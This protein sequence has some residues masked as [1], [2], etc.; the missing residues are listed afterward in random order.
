LS[1][2]L[3]FSRFP[4]FLGLLLKKFALLIVALALVISACGGGD[5]E[6]AATVDG[7]DYTVGDV[8]DLVFDSGETVSKEQF[9]QFLGFLV[10]YDIV[11]NAAEE[12][13]GITFTED[14]I[15]EEA[16]EIYTENADEGTTYEEFL[17]A[18][19]VSEE[20]LR[21]VAHLQ[22]VEEG[23]RIEL[24]SELEAPAQEDIDAQRENAYDSLT[25]V[26]G[27]HIL[28][29][30]EAEAQE[31]LDRLED[32]EEFA[33]LATELSL[34][35]GSGEAGG[36]LG[37]ADPTGYVPE[38]AE[39]MLAAEIDVPTEPVE[40]EFGYHVI[41]VSERTFPEEADLPTDEEIIESLRVPAVNQALTD[42]IS[43]H[44]EAAEV[45]INEKFGT[46]QSSPAGVIPPVE[47]TTPTTSLDTGTTTTGEPTEE[48]TTTTGE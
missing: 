14:E 46:W 23:V 40:T 11:V 8:N 19:E 44:L 7:T 15:D 48:T 28:V 27:S 9:A 43:G 30:T 3:P 36:D 16:Q 13:Y 39:A 31:V 12:D 37:C 26:C 21:K 22:L 20:F 42:W 5:G 10:Q 24:E 1:K 18:N 6:T 17:E 45:E 34:D 25:E 4:S 33:D 38:F 2:P 47:D 29:E 32:G 41:V 35:T